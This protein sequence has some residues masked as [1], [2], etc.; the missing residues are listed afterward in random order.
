MNELY[1]IPIVICRSELVMKLTNEIKTTMLQHT[2]AAE[3]A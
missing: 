1:I 2:I 3:V